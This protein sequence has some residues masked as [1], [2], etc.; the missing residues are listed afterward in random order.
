MATE[1]EPAVVTDKPVATLR[2]WVSLVLGLAGVTACVAYGPS[3]TNS[4]ND[5]LPEAVGDT[6]MEY[7]ALFIL[8]VFVP[9]LVI[10][11]L[12]NLIDRMGIWSTGIRPATNL[13]IGL[14]TGGFGIAC[15]FAMAFVANGVAAG[16]SSGTPAS[17]LLIGWLLMV[18]QA[19]TEEL[20]FRGW[21]Q[22]RFV[23]VLGPAIGIGIT[24]LL[25]AAIHAFGMGRAPISLINL[26]LGG[27]WF[28]LLA[29]RTHGLLAPIG[30]HFAWNGTE[31]LILGID[32]NPGLAIP[33][34][35]FDYDLAGVAIWG[36][37]GEGMNASAAMTLVLLALIA[38]LA[39]P[40]KSIEPGAPEPRLS[41]PVPS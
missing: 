28:G 34:S 2:T 30:A 36:G 31:Q 14:A 17:Y 7:Y 24:A 20:V 13:M 4:L 23:A 11:G 19:G 33:G 39:W 26:F 32:P 18:V 27:I 12:L 8:T 29:F 9:M 21:A 6:D 22:R 37:S 10:I 16:P 5:W 15:A 35:L 38:P 1:T 40:R 41:D 25:F 3:L